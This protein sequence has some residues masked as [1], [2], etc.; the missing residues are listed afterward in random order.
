MRIA[1]ISDL[2]FTQL[3][4]NPRWLCP[5]R[6][7]GMLNWLLFRRQNNCHDSLNELPRL[8]DQLN[9]DIILVVGDLS[10]TSLPKEFEKARKYFDQF[11][12]AKLFIPGNHDQYT[13]SSSQKGLFYQF[14][15]NTTYPS[16]HPT[17]FYSL[18][19]HKIEVH[20]IQPSWWCVALD[21]AI[22]TSLVSSHG[23]FFSETENYLEKILR[24]LPKND[25]IVLLNH[26]SFFDTDPA[27]HRLH[28]GERLKAILKRYPNIR[29]F[30]HGHTHRHSIAD[31]QLNNLPLI[32]DCGC[33]IQ[34]NSSTWN[35]ID[36]SNDGCSIKGYLWNGYQW[37][38]FKERDV[39]WIR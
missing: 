4:C 23:I 20:P 21:T 13:R 39:A 10:S 1:Q 29:L 8:M 38:V 14:F 34:K 7:A 36:L 5:K 32:C 30:L 2:H 22:P 26:F 31:L 6:I 37:E 28:N 33:P 35:L 17:Q 25:Q 24:S 3:T 19:D 12:Q 11:K 27:T 18:A 16:E 9:V 15:K